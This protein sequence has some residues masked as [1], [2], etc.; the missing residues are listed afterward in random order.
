MKKIMAL[1]LIFVIAASLVACGQTETETIYVQTESVRTIGENQIRMEYAYSDTGV[2]LSL[3]SYL[4][5]KLYQTIDYRISNGLQFLTVTD[6]EGNITTQSTETKY[7]DKGRVMQVTSAVGGTEVA[8]TNYT[9]DDNDK[10]ISTMA[11]TASASVYT[12]YTYGDNGWVVSTLAVDQ[13]TGKYTR[14][15][16]VYNE[17]GDVIKE[18]I[19]SAEDTMAEAK[20]ISYN[21]DKS[22]IT[23]TYLDGAGEP[24][25]E[26]TVDYYD[27]HGNKVKSVTTINGEVAMTTV[28]TFEA[29]EVPVT[30]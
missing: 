28:N 3:K 13:N 11:V 23:T 30:K 15:D 5:N 21:A 25:G 6:S 27:E 14:T 17:A 2:P 12:T 29:M 19:F 7:D 22:E 9:Y 18:S 10:L 16:Y 1:L 20:T 8:Y 24:T 4:N 26:V